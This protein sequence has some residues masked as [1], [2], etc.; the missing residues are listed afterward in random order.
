MTSIFPSTS[1]RTCLQLMLLVSLMWVG[2]IPIGHSHAALTSSGT[3]E[4]DLTHHLLIHHSNGWCHNAGCQWHLHWVFRGSSYA[5][6]N[7]E[8]SVAQPLLN[9]L[10]A[11]SELIECSNSN[12]VAACFSGLVS[13]SPD[14]AA[15]TNLSASDRLKIH[16]LYRISL[17]TFS[18]VMRC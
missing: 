14:W 13:Q 3:C 5:G 2:P 4:T 7:V 16:Q 1:I 11:T 18:S 12:R 8:A 6:F 9:E 10:A 17:P 15:S